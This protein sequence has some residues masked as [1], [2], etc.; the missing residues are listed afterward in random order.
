MTLGHR[1]ALLAALGLSLT[2]A[3]SASARA[4]TI[5]ASAP[6]ALRP[7]TWEV[8]AGVRTMYIKSAGFDPFS[9]NDGFVQFSLSGL[10]VVARKGS[11]L[12]RRR[13]GPGRRQLQRHRER[14][15][16]Q[17]LAHPPVG[18]GRRTVPT[19]VA[20]L[21]LC[22]PRAG[23]GARHGDDQRRVVPLGLRADDRLR[24]L[25]TGRQRRRRLL[26]GRGRH[27]P[28]RRLAARRRRIQLGRRPGSRP[29]P[30]A[31]Q[32]RPEQ[33]RHP[34]PRHPRPPRRLLPHLHGRL[35]VTEPRRAAHVSRSGPAPSGAGPAPCRA[36]TARRPSARPRW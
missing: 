19:L 14:R 25:L 31:Q 1:K 22:A 17:P 3:V 28:R 9:T 2:G 18:A 13:G 8:S 20:A 24:R 11:P 35:Q 34:R 6:P 10:G 30:D 36:G 4:Q 32:R 29:R 26:P 33:G 27:R 15:T 7:P 23:P 12:P 5:E 21:S 16:L